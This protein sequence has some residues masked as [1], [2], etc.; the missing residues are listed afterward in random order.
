MKLSTLPAS[1]IPASTKAGVNLQTLRKPNASAPSA[2]QGPSVSTKMI[3]AAPS[4][5]RMEENVAFWKEQIRLAFAPSFIQAVLA[6]ITMTLASHTA[7]TTVCVPLQDL[8]PLVI[9]FPTSLA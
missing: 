8:V 6:S 2:T 4:R 1:Q 3:H 7:K 5:A 9:V